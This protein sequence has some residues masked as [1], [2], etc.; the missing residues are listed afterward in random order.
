MAPAVGQA[1]GQVVKL[2]Q[3]HLQF[4][5]VTTR[6]LREYIENQAGSIDH[7]PVQAG[8]EITLLRRGQFMVED[9]DIGP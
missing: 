1:G 2:S 8:F 3:F 4:A 5:F 7:A 6:P 9:Y